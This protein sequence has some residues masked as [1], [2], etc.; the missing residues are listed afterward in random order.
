MTTIS[1]DTDIYG[2]AVRGRTIYY[3]T[4]NNGLRMLNLSDKSVSNII[5]SK[6]SYVCYVATSGGKLCYTGH[7][8]HTVTC[9][10]LHGTTQREFKDDRVLQFPRGISVDNDGNVCV[11]GHFSNNV[12]VISP[13]GQ[14]HRQ[15]LSSKDY[16]RSTNRLLVVNNSSTAFL[17]DV[18]RD[19]KDEKNRHQ[20]IE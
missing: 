6:L 13:D 8:I 15:L 12:V 17:F 1:M 16:D 10:D 5:N 19:R 2:M 9:C 11:V 7:Q 18:T 14:R 20:F 3:C 4:R